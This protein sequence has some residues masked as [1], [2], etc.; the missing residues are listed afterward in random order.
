[1]DAN[2]RIDPNFKSAYASLKQYHRSYTDNAG[3]VWRGRLMTA[4]AL[5]GLAWLLLQGFA[6]EARVNGA[7][8]ITRARVTAIARTPGGWRATTA[9]G[10]FHGAL[11]V[12]AAGAWAD[13]L[14]L[15][16][17]IRP[18]GLTPLRRSMA[19]SRSRPAGEITSGV[20]SLT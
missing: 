16:A 20:M 15:L 13:Q 19:R 1:M 18:L 2:L 17:G 3:S 4:G 10:D 9:A 8:I 7:Q 5:F 12:N 11:L 14:A 6:R